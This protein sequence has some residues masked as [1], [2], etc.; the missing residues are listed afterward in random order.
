MAD[1]DLEKSTA[2][3]NTVGAD[4]NPP[5]WTKRNFE[6]QTRLMEKLVETTSG[7][8]RRSRRKVECFNC[9]DIFI[10]KQTVHATVTKI[11]IRETPARRDYDTGNPARAAT[12]YRATEA[13][14][15][16]GDRKCHFHTM[17]H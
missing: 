16:Y 17:R 6:Q 14:S 8:P 3:V 10:T 11:T 9:G 13:R 1:L 4:T 2:E 12:T 5:T 7:V 15:Q